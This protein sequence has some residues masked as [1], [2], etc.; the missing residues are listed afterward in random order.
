MDHHHIGFW[1]GTQKQTQSF[2]AIVQA[3]ALWDYKTQRR[4]VQEISYDYFCLYSGD[5]CQSTLAHSHMG[6]QFFVTTNHLEL[7]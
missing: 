1:I 5:K 6:Y 7:K 4:K 3:D 2:M